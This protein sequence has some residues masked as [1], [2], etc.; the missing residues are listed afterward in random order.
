[1]GRVVGWVGEWAMGERVVGWVIG[2]VGSGKEWA[3]GWVGER[4]VGW[5]WV[6]ERAVGWVGECKRTWRES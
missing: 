1:M 5:E 3:V 2:W 6:R 4:A